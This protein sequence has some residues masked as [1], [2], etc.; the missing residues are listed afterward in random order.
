MFVFTILRLES[1]QYTVLYSLPTIVADRSVP[2]DPAT[3]AGGAVW[4]GKFA[5]VTFIDISD[6]FSEDESYVC[7]SSYG[8]D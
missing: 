6:M 7:I 1:L 2:P 3:D 5:D 4:I 8:E